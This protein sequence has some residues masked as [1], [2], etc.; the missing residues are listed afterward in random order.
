MLSHDVQDCILDSVGQKSLDAFFRYLIEIVIYAIES[1]PVE[2]EYEPIR[3]FGVVFI[4]EEQ[5]VYR[6]FDAYTLLWPR[7]HCFG[8][9]P[10]EYEAVSAPSD[11][12]TFVYGPFLEYCHGS[13]TE[14]YA[15]QHKDNAYC[16]ANSCN[17]LRDVDVFYHVFFPF[18]KMKIYTLYAKT[19]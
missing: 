15:Q 16:Y 4:I 6:P 8:E 12:F 11:F 10:E 19:I 14:S 7:H 17:G 3:Y 18:S 9:W 13:E 5:T 2:M 1:L